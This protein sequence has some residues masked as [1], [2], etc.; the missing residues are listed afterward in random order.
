LS[1]LL[2][3]EYALAA[4]ERDVSRAVDTL[5]DGVSR[6]QAADFDDVGSTIVEYAGELLGGRGVDR[7]HGG[8][9]EVVD[10]FWYILR[11]K[12]G[13]GNVRDR[14]KLRAVFED[15][16]FVGLLDK[17]TLRQALTMVR[18]YDRGNTLAD[19]VGA[20]HWRPDQ[21]LYGWVTAGVALSRWHELDPHW[22]IVTPAIE[23]FLCRDDIDDTPTTTIIELIDET[24]NLLACAQ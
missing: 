7:L 6:L 10:A 9:E 12:V 14:R 1:T 15:T 13:A 17:D 16:T 8:A 23:A 5:M 22:A 18:L 20:D 3:D 21:Q 19:L 24:L 4:L 2:G 11:S